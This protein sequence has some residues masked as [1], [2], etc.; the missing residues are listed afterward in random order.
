MKHAIETYV[1]VALA[2]LFSFACGCGEADRQADRKTQWVDPKTVQLGP[3]LRDS[4]TDEQM[5]RVRRLQQV[6]QEVDP[7]P[8]EKWVEDFRSEPDPEE[9][10]SMWEGMASAYSAY[11]ASRSLTPEAK[12]EV[13]RVVLMR[14]AASEVDVLAHAELKILADK[15][16]R[17]IM[18]LY[19]QTPRPMR[20]VSP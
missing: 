11:T 14:S 16:A 20:A 18:R 4:L 1:V 3:A 12:K 8:V 2:A 13:F 10:L 9:E 19:S 17:E 6:F 15:D 7:S 5:L